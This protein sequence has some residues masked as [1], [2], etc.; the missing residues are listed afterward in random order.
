MPWP[1]NGPVVSIAW[2]PPIPKSGGVAVTDLAAHAK[3]DDHRLLSE[4]FA[5]DDPFVRAQSLKLLSSFGGPE[6]SRELIA[7]LADP[8]PNV[9]AAVLDTFAET[10]DARV[11]GALVKYAATETN[12]DLVVH[13]VHVLELTPGDDSFDAL[14]GML[15][16]PQWRVRGEAAE[17]FTG[18]LNEAESN[19]IAPEDKQEATQALVKLLDDPDGYVVSRAAGTLIKSAFE[20]SARA[21]MK[22][23]PNRPDLA[24]DVLKA[25][26]EQSSV[27]QSFVP[28]IRLLTASTRPPEVTSRA[29][30]PVRGAGVIDKRRRRQR[31]VCRPAGSCRKRIF[32]HGNDQRHPRQRHVA[33]GAGR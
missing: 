32:L 20:A 7:L 16:H 17:A 6:T 10:P 23:V 31:R 11:V 24:P 3:P 4:M 2:P 28:R 18:K 12:T 30:R 9:R 25:L 15:K 33:I 22:R 8:E 14:Q 1:P 27:G 29:A 26:S 19:G 5:D 13:V 21:L